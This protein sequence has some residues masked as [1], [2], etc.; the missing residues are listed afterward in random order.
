MIFYIAELFKMMRALPWFLYFVSL[1]CFISGFFLPIVET[2][3][4]FIFK[5]TAYSTI[6][7]SV[8]LFFR[9]GDIGMGI[10]IFFFTILF[11]AIK[12]VDLVD[13]VAELKLVKNKMVKS[14]LKA[15]NKYSMLDVFVIAVLIVAIKLEKRFISVSISTGTI[16][17]AL[18]IIIRLIITDILPHIKKE[19]IKTDKE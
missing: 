12:Y 3:S 16:L 13:D 5:D 8:M 14:V 19:E 17:F 9:Q 4:G 10:I 15:L 6:W 2:T 1:S 18:S 11:P 7:D